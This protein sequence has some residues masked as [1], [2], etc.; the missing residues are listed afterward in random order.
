MTDIWQH[1]DTPAHF[2]CPAR[3]QV[4]TYLEGDTD[5]VTTF[6]RAV[7]T[8]D[9]ITDPRTG[10]CWL[11]VIRPDL[12]TA[13]LDVATVIDFGSSRHPYQAAEGDGPEDQA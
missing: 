11:P 1:P 9:M 8:G 10:R 4:V 13:L 5:D 3:G 2:R 6:G 12:T 7:A